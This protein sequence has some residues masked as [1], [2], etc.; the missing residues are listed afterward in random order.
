LFTKSGTSS[1]A[2]VEIRQSGTTTDPALVVSGASQ[3][4]EVNTAA[5]G[6]ANLLP[7][8][9]GRIRA[10]GTVLNGTGNFTVT[11]P[12]P[13]LG[14]Y[15]ITITSPGNLNLT[16][17]ICV[18]S[19]RIGTTVSVNDFSAAAASGGPNGLVE[20]EVRR[21]SNPANADEQGFNFVIYRP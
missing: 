10:D 7:L 12:L 21:L 2:V 13:G 19:C 20:V 14:L 1:G 8:A 6:T 16:N 18:V 17:A 5:T 9:Y 11:Q 3:L 15:N 4:Q